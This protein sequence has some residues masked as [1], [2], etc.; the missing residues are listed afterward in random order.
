MA[1][2]NFVHT[3][4]PLENSFFLLLLFKYVHIYCY[5]K[6]SWCGWLHWIIIFL[7][8]SVQNLIWTSYILGERIF[9]NKANRVM[10]NIWWP[11][12]LE[13]PCDIL[14]TFKTPLLKCSIIWN[15]AGKGWLKFSVRLIMFVFCNLWLIAVFSSWFH[16]LLVHFIL[17]QITPYPTPSPHPSPP[18]IVHLLY[19]C[20]IIY[21]S[22]F[23][24]YVYVYVFCVS[25]LFSKNTF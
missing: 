1:A 17:S 18:T 23:I 12:R 11:Q 14:W 19:P 5:W 8:I 2:H 4:S 22:L 20:S 7:N 10:V 15:M 13:H 21:I 16:W 6:W 24:I 25:T 9:I 3:N